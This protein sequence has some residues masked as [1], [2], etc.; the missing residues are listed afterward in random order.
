MNQLFVCP[1]SFFVDGNVLS[2]VIHVPVT[3]T[4]STAWELYQFH[5]L[6]TRVGRDWYRI[7]PEAEF[8]ATDNARS[9][10]IVFTAND[11]SRCTNDHHDH[12][13]PDSHPRLRNGHNSC[14]TALF[15]GTQHAIEELC[16]CDKVKQRHLAVQVNESTTFIADEQETRY[17]VTCA[18]GD[19]ETFRAEGLNEFALDVGCRATSDHVEIPTRGPQLEVIATLRLPGPDYKLHWVDP[20]AWTPPATN[21][22]TLKNDFKEKVRKIEEADLPRGRSWLGPTVSIL[23]LIGVLCSSL[24]LVEQVKAYCGKLCCFRRQEE[25]EP[26]A[27]EHTVGR[28]SPNTSS[29]MG[30]E[31]TSF[32]TAPRSFPTP[33]TPRT[34]PAKR[35]R[36]GPSPSRLPPPRG[37]DGKTVT[38]QP[39]R[40]AP[41]AQL[42][43]RPLREEMEE[44]PIIFPT[45]ETAEER[46]V[47]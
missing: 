39:G 38:Q 43:Q 36:R 28:W 14:L 5:P 37:L 34:P 22:T 10:F 27:E 2:A 40:T 41:V 13:C 29:S 46:V 17:E 21:L 25:E 15:L 35:P 42:A 47:Q 24:C 30:T 31:E 20:A 12:W 32:L 6:P 26:E 7:K 19:F 8:L 4:D 23:F 1:V 16:P 11:L 33:P 44:E 9:R 45:I 3:H 18:D